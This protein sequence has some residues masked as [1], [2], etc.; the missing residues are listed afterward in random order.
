MDDPMLFSKHALPSGMEMYYQYRPHLSWVGCE[1]IIW[2]GTR[3]C[4]DGK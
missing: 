2:A 1:V 3:H 4:P